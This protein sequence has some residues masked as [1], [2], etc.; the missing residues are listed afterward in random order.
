[1]IKH[2][3]GCVCQCESVPEVGS[4]SVSRIR[5]EAVPSR[6]CRLIMSTPARTAAFMSVAKGRPNIV[7]SL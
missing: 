6:G 1:M 3:L 2:P 5:M 4:P 7:V